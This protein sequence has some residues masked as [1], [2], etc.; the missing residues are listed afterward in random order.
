MTTLPKPVLPQSAVVTSEP[1]DVSDPQTTKGE[2]SRWL[3]EW[4]DQPFADGR[5][6]VPLYVIAAAALLG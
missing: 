2:E 5:F 4:A 1:H 3:S 6:P